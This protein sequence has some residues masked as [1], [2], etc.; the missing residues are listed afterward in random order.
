MNNDK[1][2]FSQSVLSVRENWEVPVRVRLRQFV[3][4]N[5]LMDTELDK[6]VARWIHT[7]APNASRR[8]KFSGR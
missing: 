2:H 5:Q 6:L 1:I 4:F 3:Q 7:A 8:S